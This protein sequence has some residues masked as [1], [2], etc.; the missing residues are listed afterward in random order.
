MVK[1]YSQFSRKRPA[2]ATPFGAPQSGRL[3]EVVV[4]GKNQDNRAFSHDVTSA[5]ILAFQ[6]NRTAAML[7]FQT[8]PVGV[9]LFSQFSYVNTFFCFHKFT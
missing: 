6:N 2:K 4:Y 5:S 1:R 8:N 7:V 3:R 9:D